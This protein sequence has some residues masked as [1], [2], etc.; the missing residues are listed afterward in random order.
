MS[1]EQAQSRKHRSPAYPFMGL[2]TAIER[3]RVV[4]EKERMHPATVP[5]MAGH[6]GFKDKSSGGLQTVSALRQFGLMEEAP[7]NGA[8]RRVKLTDAARRLIVLP[9]DNPERPRLLAEAARKPTLYA[10]LLEKWGSELPSDQNLR[11]YL[12]LERNFNESAVDGAIRNFRSSI[13]FAGLADAG[14]MSGQEAAGGDDSIGLTMDPL[15]AMRTAPATAAQSS[16]GALA[17][18]VPYG[19]GTIAVQVRATGQPITSAMLARVR[20]YLELAEE[21]ITHDAD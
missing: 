15:P 20:K 6:W 19:K 16:D 21:D 17:L 7:G 8:A 12:L 14:T 4:Y 13:S 10:E 5:V 9:A 1:D 2:E 11:T 3:A 18:S